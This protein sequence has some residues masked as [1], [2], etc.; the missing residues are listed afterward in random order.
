[1]GRLFVVATPI[2]N[3]GDITLRAVETL[4]T[5]R[6][7]AAED[8]RRTRQLLRHLQIA[9]PLLSYHAHNQRMRQPRLLAE[10]AQ[11]DVALV[12]DAG[13]PVVSDP[14]AELVAAAA[15]AGN[16]VLSVPGPSAPVAALSVCG[17]SAPSFHCVGFLPRRSGERRRAL[18]AMAGWPGNMILFEAPHRLRATLADLLEVFGDRQVAVCCELTKLFEHVERTTLSG[19]V[20]YY[21]EMEPRGEFTLVVAGG[22]GLAQGPARGVAGG[23][24]ASEGDDQS[25]LEERFGALQAAH[26]DRKRALAALAVETGL[27]RKVLYARLMTGAAGQKGPA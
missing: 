18:T 1:V 5:V 22:Q 23:A 17:F 13:T 4:R 2:G 15:A 9:T 8:T 7:I 19:A 11:G 3:L 10:L 20:A 12:S 14:G 6:L 16:E 26:G 24:G 21:Q 27:P 25:G